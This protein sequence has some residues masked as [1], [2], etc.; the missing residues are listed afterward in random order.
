MV[1]TFDVGQNFQV[2]P[3]WFRTSKPKYKRIIC[4]CPG[5]VHFSVF[6]F[7][8]FHFF[9]KGIGGGGIGM[10]NSAYHTMLELKIGTVTNKLEVPK[11]VIHLLLLFCNLVNYDYHKIYIKYKN[12]IPTHSGLG[13]NVS[14]NTSIIWGLNLLF[15]CPFSI[16]ELYDILTNN[17]VENSSDTRICFGTGTGVG[18][19]ALLFGGIVLVDVQGKLIG[20]FQTKNITIL[21]AHG[22][23]DNLI[24]NKTRK[25][26]SKV[27]NMDEEAEVYIVKS[28]GYPHMRLYQKKI[29]EIVNR[30]LLPLANMDNQNKLINRCKEL[31]R[32]G[33]FK[34]HKKIMKDFVLNRFQN[35]TENK[36][37][38]SG[39]S[40]AGPAMFAIFSSKKSAQSFKINY[41]KRYEKYFKNF[42]VSKGGEK[43]HAILIE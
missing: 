22:I 37:I 7:K 25:A 23:L 4:K 19:A 29:Y 5:R 13:S 43:I 15:G 1:Q 28:I 8:K 2:K 12:T 16:L 11:T 36:A 30:I 27:V 35:D 24:Q 9:D 17:F 41:E 31:N 32:Y 14:S 18:E 21:T 33:T 38:Y 39:I 3:E 26:L 40:S 42:K 20:N 34:F 10:S 6:D